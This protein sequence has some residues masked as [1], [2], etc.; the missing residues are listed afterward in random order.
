MRSK[1]L[2]SA[3]PRTS[4]IFYLG[5]RPTWETERIERELHIRFESHQRAGAHKRGAEWFNASPELLKY[6]SEHTHRASSMS[7]PP[8][9]PTTTWLDSSA[10]SAKNVADHR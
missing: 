1:V 5:E 7:K 3:S 4:R 10:I 6:V 2:L 8:T 9:K